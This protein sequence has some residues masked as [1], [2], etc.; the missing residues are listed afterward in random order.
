MGI[1]ENDLVNVFEIE[2]LPVVNSVD[3]QPLNKTDYEILELLAQNVQSQLLDQVRVINVGQKIVIWI[4]N[5]ISV[6]VL[7]GKN[8]S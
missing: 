8:G 5:N 3:I 1:N 4:G 7:I 6:I 2:Q